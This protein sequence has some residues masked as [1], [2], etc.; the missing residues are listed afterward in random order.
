MKVIWWYLL[1]S[2]TTQ[3][4]ISIS[5]LIEP[6]AMSITNKEEEVEPVADTNDSTAKEEQQRNKKEKRKSDRQ[7][8]KDYASEV[9]VTT[10]V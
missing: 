8:T 4:V 5:Y 1:E 10:A 6:Y 3:P 7:L 2:K 9:C